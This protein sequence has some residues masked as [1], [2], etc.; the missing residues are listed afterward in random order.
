VKTMQHRAR[1]FRFYFRFRFCFIRRNLWLDLSRRNLWFYVSRSTFIGFISV[2]SQCAQ[3]ACTM[4]ANLNK[5]CFE[6]LDF[7]SARLY[8]SKCRHCKLSML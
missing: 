2:S 7:V 1:R 5:L 3:H 6:S 8:L 4:N